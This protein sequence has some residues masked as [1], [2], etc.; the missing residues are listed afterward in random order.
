[1]FKAFELKGII[2]RIVQFVLAGFSAWFVLRFAPNDHDQQSIWIPVGVA[3][4]YF[5][6]A[7]VVYLLP[8]ILDNRKI[9]VGKY[10]SVHDTDKTLAIF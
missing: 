1:M 8:H 9:F 5:V 4:L 10:L 3:V 7:M 6:L 2:E